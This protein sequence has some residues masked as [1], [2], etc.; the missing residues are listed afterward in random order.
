MAYCLWS[1]FTVPAQVI[2]KISVFQ[3]SLAV[4]FSVDHPVLNCD[5]QR[6]CLALKPSV[7]QPEVGVLGFSPTL[8]PLS[9]VLAMDLFDRQLTNSDA[10]LGLLYRSGS[11]AGQDHCASKNSSLPLECIWEL[12]FFQDFRCCFSQGPSRLALQKVLSLPHTQAVPVIHRI[13]QVRRCRDDRLL[14]AAFKADEASSAHCSRKIQSLQSRVIMLAF[15]PPKDSPRT[16]IEVFQFRASPL[17][18]A[19]IIPIDRYSPGVG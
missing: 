1:F 13:R 18:A 12:V 16:H 11:V 5:C 4:G 2:R 8:L 6:F 7:H 10:L 9:A 14:P 17:Q 19:E 15:M 3:D